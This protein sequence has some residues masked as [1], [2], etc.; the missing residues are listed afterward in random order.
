MLKTHFIEHFGSEICEI[1]LFVE[2]CCSKFLTICVA[3]NL[4]C[5]NNLV[6]FD[7]VQKK[8]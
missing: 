1:V 7:A 8:H 5:T 2:L 3:K 6:G 4:N